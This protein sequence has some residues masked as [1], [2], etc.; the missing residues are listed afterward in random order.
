MLFRSV[1]CGIDID[2]TPVGDPSDDDYFDRNCGK[3]KLFPMGPECVFNGITVL[4]MVR[5]SPSD[6]ITSV[7]LWDTLVTM[8]HYG[9]FDLSSGKKL[10]LILDRVILSFPLWN[11]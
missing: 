9:L 5:W 11:T 4:Y 10:F 6:S 7:I 1:E 2:A 8:D 3:G